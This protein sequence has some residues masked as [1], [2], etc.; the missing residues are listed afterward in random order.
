MRVRGGEKLIE[1][2]SE[3]EGE[4]WRE[5]EK[6]METDGK[7]VGEADKERMEKWRKEMEKMMDRE[8]IIHILNNFLLKKELEFHYDFFPIYICVIITFEYFR[9]CTKI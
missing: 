6:D 3:R 2:E 7:R 8:S 4:R 1:G 5:I 9:D